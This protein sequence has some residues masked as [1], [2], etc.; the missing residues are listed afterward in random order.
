MEKLRRYFRLRALIKEHA[1]TEQD[2]INDMYLMRHI[3]EDGWDSELQQGMR[4][5]I[6]F[7]R[8]WRSRFVRRLKA[9]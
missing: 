1:V 8:A 3:K 6:I 4:E 9:L 5:T 2:L 7:M